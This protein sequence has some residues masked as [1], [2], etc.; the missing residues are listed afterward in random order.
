MSGHDAQA[1]AALPDPRR[2]VR[3]ASEAESRIRDKI[4]MHPSLKDIL[5]LRVPK[6]L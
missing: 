3:S 2:E 5:E 1:S 6:L 4:E